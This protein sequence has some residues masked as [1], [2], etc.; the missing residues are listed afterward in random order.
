[1]IISTI[2]AGPY[3]NYADNQHKTLTIYPSTPGSK[4]SVDFTSFYLEDYYDYLYIY[5]GSSTS[6]TLIG[7]YTSTSGPGTVT[8]TAS[9]GS[10]TFEFISDAYVNTYGWEEQFPV[11]LCQHVPV[12][13][14][15]VP[16]FLQLQQP[17]PVFLS[18]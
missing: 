3:S 5:N 12:R 18:Y 4:V 15:P 14:P 9:D 16:L 13:F 2:R 7:S 10:L 17:V 11:L 6:A 1:M 8:S